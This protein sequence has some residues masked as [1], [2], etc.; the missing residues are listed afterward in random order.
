[1]SAWKTKNQATISISIPLNA[2]E[3][4][5][6][7]EEERRSDALAERRQ[8]LILDCGIIW[9][10]IGPSEISQRDREHRETSPL[11]PVNSLANNVKG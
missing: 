3:S 5:I 8:K 1:M 10:L 7:E 11:C 6:V 9:A 2:L 4:Q